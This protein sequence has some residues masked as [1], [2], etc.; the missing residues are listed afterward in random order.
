LHPP[1]DNALPA[2]RIRSA[3][4]QRIQRVVT[5]QANTGAG[6]ELGAALAHDAV[7]DRNRLPAVDFYA[8]VVGIGIAP[9]A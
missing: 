2:R 3:I 4:G 1:D 7:A 6:M 8:Q 5:P 9:V